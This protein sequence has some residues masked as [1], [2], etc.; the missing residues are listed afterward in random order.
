MACGQISILEML[1]SEE[2]KSSRICAYN[3]TKTLPLRTDSLLVQPGPV[4]PGSCPPGPDV[5]EAL[6]EEPGNGRDGSTQ[7][8][9]GDPRPNQVK[10]QAL[11]DIISKEKIFQEVQN[12]ANFPNIFA[13]TNL[14]PLVQIS[15][16]ESNLKVSNQ[17]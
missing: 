13:K 2:N 15:S 7:K 3:D 10:L 6:P 5:R 1:F 12:P 4:P 16:L 17:R 11:L 9:A 14:K 8:D